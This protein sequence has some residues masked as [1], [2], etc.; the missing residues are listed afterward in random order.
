MCICIYVSRCCLALLSQSDLAAHQD[1][2]GMEGFRGFGTA[3]KTSPA[4]VMVEVYSKASVRRS[5]VKMPNPWN[6]KK[7]KKPSKLYK[8]RKVPLIARD[9][10]FPQKNEFVGTANLAKIRK[11]PLIT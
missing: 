8:I 2:R 6:A 4:I 7:N 9:R 1:C 3:K 11:A 5:V 10:C